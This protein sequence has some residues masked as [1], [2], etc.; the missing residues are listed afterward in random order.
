MAARAKKT[1]SKTSSAKTSVTSSVKPRSTRSSVKEMDMP[2]TNSLQSSSETKKQNKKTLLLLILAAL[3]LGLLYYYKDLFV[4]ATVNG[5]P[6]SRYAVVSDLEKQN[7]KGVVDNLVTKELIL[8]EAAKKDVS[9][10][11]ADIDAE[12]GKIEEDLK[13][14]GQ[15]LDQVLT[16][17]GLTREDVTENLQIKL[18][19][20]KILNEKVQVSDEDAQKYFDENKATFSKDTK[21]EDQKDTIKDQLKQQKLQEEYQ[22]WMDEL[23]AN[24]KI[25]YFKTY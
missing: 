4:V 19:I 15:T 23:K 11:Q 20:E 3:V 6:I 9:V 24:A 16:M 2:M 14:Q 13:A 8:Q 22:T 21:F 25:N 12:L 7:G 17:Q 5:K 10:T 18:Y 1:T